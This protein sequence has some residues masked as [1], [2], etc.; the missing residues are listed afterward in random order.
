MEVRWNRVRTSKSRRGGWEWKNKTEMDA[1]G[2][3]KEEVENREEAEAMGK[4]RK[5]RPMNGVRVCLEI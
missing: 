4:G 3:D 1:D 2:I 5:W